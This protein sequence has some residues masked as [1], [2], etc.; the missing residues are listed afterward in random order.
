MRWFF[1]YLGIFLIAIQTSYYYLWIVQ[2]IGL[3]ILYKTSEILV[4]YSKTLA[5]YQ[6]YE[7]SYFELYTLK[8]TFDNTIKR[9]IINYTRLLILSYS[10][11]IVFELF[12]LKIGLE[13]SV[14][15]PLVLL[16]VITV[17]L[18]YSPLIFGSIKKYYA[19]KD[20]ANS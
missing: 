20:K 13:A 2:F 8:R 9:Y 6:S 7:D 12:P 10:I 14:V 19:K 18:F 4:K 16:P 3:I 11:L 1:F 17:A 5:N 15:L